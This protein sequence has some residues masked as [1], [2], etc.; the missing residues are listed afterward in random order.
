[1][2]RA[3]KAT[4]T[5]QKR[6]PGQNTSQGGTHAQ[7]G[8]ILVLINGIKHLGVSLLY[9]QSPPPPPPSESY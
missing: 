5:F 4:G 6:A 7:L 3:R 1:M 9:F 2:A 8:L